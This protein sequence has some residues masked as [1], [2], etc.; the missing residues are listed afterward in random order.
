VAEQRLD[1]RSD[2]FSLGALGYLM[3]TERHAFAARS[4]ADLGEAWK[5]RIPAPSHFEPDV[6]KALDELIVSLLS[7]NAVGRPSSAAEVFN[8]LSAIAALPAAEAPEVARAYLTTPALVGRANAVRQ[9]RHVLSRANQRHGMPMVIE[10]LEGL[11]RSRLLSSFLMDA[12]LE[13]YSTLRADASSADEGPLGVG[14]ALARRLFMTDPFMARDAAGENAALLSS[15]LF[16]SDGAALAPAGDEARSGSVVEALSSMFLAAAEARPL[17]VGVDDFER[18]DPHSKQFVV[19]LATLSQKSRLTIVVTLSRDVH[20]EAHALL[21]D[22]AS[23]LT[24]APLTE[25]ETRELVR[26]LFGDVPNIEGV[27]RWVHQ[28]SSGRPRAAMEVANH[29][30]ENGVVEYEEGLWTLPARLD[31]RGLPASVDQALDSKI[32]SLGPDALALCR[33]LALSSEQEPLLVREYGELFDGCSG[34]RLDVAMNE[35]VGRSIVVPMPMTLTFAHAGLREAARRSIPPE[36]LAEMHRRVAAAYRSGQVPSLALSSY[37]SLEAGDVELAFEQA[38]RA[39][40]RRKTISV[41]GSAFSRTPEGIRAFETLFE[42]GLSNQKSWPETLALGQILLQLAAV[43]DMRLVR[44]APKILER[45]RLDSGLVDH[46]ALPPSLDPLERIRTGIGQAMARYDATEVS[47][48]GLPALAA[49]EALCGGVASLAGAYSRRSEPLE[50]ARLLSLLDPFRP[51]SPAAAVVADMVAFSVDGLLGRDIRERRLRVLETLSAPVPGLD[52]ISRVGMYWMNLFYEALEEAANGVQS[53]TERVQPLMSDAI[54]APLGWEVH[55]VAAL[56]L[57]DLEGA[58]VARRERD[59]AN[60]TGSFDAGALLDLGLLYEAGAADLSGDVLRLK[61]FVAWLERQS[62]AC[63]AVAAFY[64][65]HLGNYHRLRG[66][67]AKALASYQ[68]AHALSPRAS[69]FGEWSYIVFRLGQALIEADRAT[70]ARELC[71]S[72]VADARS[73][74]VAPR[75]SQRIEMTLAMAEAALGLAEDAEARSERAVTAALADGL[76]GVFLVTS[77]GDQG[78]VAEL[79]GNREL[80]DRVI[81]RLETLAAF[82]RHPALA[83]KHVHLLRHAQGRGQLQVLPNPQKVLGGSTSTNASVVTGIRTQIELCRGRGERARRA[84]KLLL[85]AAASDEGF[86]YLCEER[87]VKLAASSVEAAPPA[88]LEAVLADHLR[89]GTAEGDTTG[90]E[91]REETTRLRS[92]RPGVDG[93]LFDVVEVVTRVRGRCVLTALAALKPRNGTLE[94]VPLVLREALSDALLSAGDTPGI[95]WA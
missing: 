5:R 57:G 24:L 79:T 2:L 67:S 19:R 32:A 13:G 26:S 30:V 23:R 86:L 39:V 10:G 66:E 12:K 25:T 50:V 78:R 9:F 6:P 1:A 82:S 69:D 61:P 44:Y 87:T 59:L 83:T 34:S 75:M 92:L 43:A 72:A 81:E 64:E 36:D 88:S 51:F 29:L 84:L 77:Y 93:P 38:V 21:R 41:R 74:N 31:L 90:D 52:E 85:D 45:L 35:L 7:L 80:L 3:L 56:F 4:V 91:E 58:A 95:P 28:L 8:R 73:N 27:T 55:V 53:A 48:R 20:G 22:V 18:L 65:L 16:P 15:L 68:R 46:D 14:A 49:I 17:V 89:S 42:W 11:G 47:E 54:Y 70:E 37:H 63:P 94:P 62:R 71:A 33:A 40:E 76:G 60:L